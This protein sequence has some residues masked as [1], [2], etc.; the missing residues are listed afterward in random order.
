MLKDKEAE[1]KHLHKER[2]QLFIT[3]ALINSICIMSIL[4]LIKVL[5]F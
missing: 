3:K 2:I 4:L 1:L 5:F